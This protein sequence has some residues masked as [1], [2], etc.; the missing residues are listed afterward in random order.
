VSDLCAC[1]ACSLVLRLQHR[2]AV[3]TEEGEQFAKEHGLI[4]LETSARTAHNVEEVRGSSSGWVKGLGQQVTAHGSRGILHLLAVH[5]AATDTR[6]IVC[7]PTQLLLLHCTRQA[8]C[9]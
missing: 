3:S 4:F 1:S 5:T 9:T 7:W 6:V 8:G 2:R